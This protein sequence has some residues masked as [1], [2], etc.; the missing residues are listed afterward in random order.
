MY[1][2]CFDDM[3]ICLCSLFCAPC[4]FGLTR[5]RAGLGHCA[6]GTFLIL[7]PMLVIYA[8]LMAVIVTPE[9]EMIKCVSDRATGTA[10]AISAANEAGI[11]DVA[12]PLHCS[13]AQQ[14]C[15]SIA[16]FNEAITTT[17]A[18]SPIIAIFMGTVRPASPSR[19][20]LY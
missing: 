18:I 16:T 19:I 3:E 5:Q 15:P 10:Q 2:Q 17:Y 11:C 7:A 9:M 1:P 6:I 8:I 14:L 4:Q 13:V 20:S 12:D